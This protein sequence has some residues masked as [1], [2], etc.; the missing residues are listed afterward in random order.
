MKFKY[1]KIKS[2]NCQGRK[3]QRFVIWTVKKKIQQKAR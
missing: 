2:L 1:N 3:Y